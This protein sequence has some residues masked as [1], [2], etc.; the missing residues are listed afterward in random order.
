MH[1][2]FT[3]NSSDID[4]WNIDLLDEH[5]DLVDTDNSSKHFVC[6]QDVLQTSPRHVLK[7]S[8][9]HAL[10]MPSRRL[11]DVFKTSSAQQFF[12]FQDVLKTKNCF[13]EDILETSSRHVLKTSWRRLEDQQ[14][15]AG[16][17]FFKQAYCYLRCVGLLG[18]TNRSTAFVNNL[19][20]KIGYNCLYIFHLIY[21]ENGI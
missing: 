3:L 8:S 5:L 20:K 7:T 19:T 2:G 6:L 21:P 12:V 10:K 18:F 13:A 16:S 14:I 15:F 17:L 9:R 11:Q 1:F 4:L